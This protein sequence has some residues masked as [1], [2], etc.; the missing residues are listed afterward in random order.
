MSLLTPTLLSL[1]APTLQSLWHE[2][3]SAHGYAH[4]WY[5]NT[6]GNTSSIG[7][8]SSLESGAAFPPTGTG[9]GANSLW[10]E[11]IDTADA[12]DINLTQ[13]DLGGLLDAAF[14]GSRPILFAFPVVAGNPAVIGQTVLSGYEATILWAGN[15]GGTVIYKTG[16]VTTETVEKVGLWWDASLD[17]A[18]DVLNSVNPESLLANPLTAA[19]FRIR[20][21]TQAVPSPLAAGK[22]PANLVGQPA[23]AW[24][25]VNVPSEAGLMAFDFTV[26]G[27]PQEDRIACAINDLNVFALP[28]KFAPDGQPVSTDMIDVSAYAGQSIELFF[29]LTGGTSTNCEVAI[30]GLRFITAPPPK[31]ALKWPAAASGWVLESSETLVP[32]NW[33]TVSTASGVTVESG[34]V[35][36]EE[37]MSGAQRFYRLRR[38]P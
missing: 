28:A 25:T 18:T 3:V 20:L 35:T 14:T 19:V 38:G 37:L 1:D 15:I 26:M 8:G 27:D 21:R 13:P 2:V 34:V 22:G 16:Q 17:A 24:L 31:V 7:F 4:A 5:R 23:Y 33:Q 9:T 6:V 30:D 11:N 32:A 36:L 12:F 29:G 10:W